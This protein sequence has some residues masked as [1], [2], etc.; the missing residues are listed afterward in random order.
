MLILLVSPRGSLQWE[1]LTPTQGPTRPSRKNPTAH[2]SCPSFVLKEPVLGLPGQGL[3]MGPLGCFLY[4]TR[5]EEKGPADMRKISALQPVQPVAHLGQCWSLNVKATCSP[6]HSWP[7]EPTPKCPRSS[8]P[9]L[10]KA[11]GEASELELGSGGTT[12]SGAGG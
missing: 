12:N 1:K 8:A 11:G 3:Q 6:P 4:P 7:W 9:T 5:W 2:F 10:G